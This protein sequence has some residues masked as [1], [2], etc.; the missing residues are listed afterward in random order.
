MLFVVKSLVVVVVVEMTPYVL[1]SQVAEL[2]TK[3]DVMISYLVF[4]VMAAEM[5]FLMTARHH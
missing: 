1:A 5:M 4:V 3:L 2:L